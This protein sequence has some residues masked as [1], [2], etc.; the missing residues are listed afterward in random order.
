MYK[1]LI[2]DPIS[3]HGL[4]ILED[5]R[6][7]LIYKPN[8]NEEELNSILHDINGWIIRSGT[9]ITAKNIKDALNLSVIGRAGVGVDNIDIQAATNAGIVVMNLPDGNT[10]SAAEH[11]MTLLSA[12]SRNVHIGHLNLIKGKWKRHELV[13][14][15]LKDKILGI[16][17]LGKIGRE[18]MKRALSYDMKIIGHD[19]FVNQE[20]FD[21][22]IVKIVDIDELTKISDFIT[23]HVPLIDST[24]NLFNLDRIKQMK[25]NSRIINVARGGI[26]NEKDL[27]FALNNEIIAGAAIDV[28]EKEPLDS[29][30]PFLKTKNL[31]ITPHLGASTIEAKEGVS[32][33]ICQ[34]VKDFLIDQKLANVLNIPIADMS[35][36][37]QIEPYL[38]MTEKLGILISQL[39]SGPVKSVKLECFGLIEELKPISISFLKGLFSRVTDNRINFINA[40]S[41]AEERGISISHSYSSKKISYSNLVKASVITANGQYSISGSVFSEKHPRIVNIMGYSI[42]VFPEGVMLFMQNKDVPGV[43]GKIGTLLGNNGINIA[44]YILSR[45]VSNKSAYSIVKVDDRI[46]DELIKE[47]SSFDEIEIINQIN[48]K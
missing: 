29:N 11:S 32:K 26:I 23:L 6:I 17:G 38:N 33:G 4:E 41:I 47:I 21:P 27:S 48:L 39:I 15:E 3:S 2:T 42:D 7:E 44:S 25:A 13:G 30:H 28:F 36:L 35:I 8:I 43:I 22:E 46:N 34:Q 37:K 19:P 18:V 16:V 14:N 40:I 24:R 31:L 10:I 9:T 45:E 5:D 12:L 20:M 1:V